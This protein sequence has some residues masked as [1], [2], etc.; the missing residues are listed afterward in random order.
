MIAYDPDTEQY[1]FDYDTNGLEPGY[2]DLFIGTNDGQIQQY[3]VEI[4]AP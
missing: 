4:T 3:R 2:Y 1:V